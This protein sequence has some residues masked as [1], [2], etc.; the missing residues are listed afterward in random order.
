MFTYFYAQS[1]MAL[2]CGKW[3]LKPVSSIRDYLF[4][5]FKHFRFYLILCNQIYYQ[6]SQTKL[7]K[8]TVIINVDI[9]QILRRSVGR[10]LYSVPCDLP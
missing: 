10:P 6:S 5:W 8:V 1:T 7:F 9:I 3:L 4:I 2:F